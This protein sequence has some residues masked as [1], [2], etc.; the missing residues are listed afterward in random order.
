MPDPVARWA[1]RKAVRDASRDAIE[2]A[3]A[4]VA[5]A[6]QVASRGRDEARTHKR[7]M[8]AILAWRTPPL[9]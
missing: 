8:R 3:Q 4:S 9:R 2:R 1:V 5:I 7:V 6:R